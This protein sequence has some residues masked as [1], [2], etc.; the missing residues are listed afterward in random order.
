[1]HNTFRRPPT[2]VRARRTRLISPRGRADRLP[3]ALAAVTTGE[4][5]SPRHHSPRDP[6]FTLLPGALFLTLT[7]MVLA[8]L[9]LA[10]LGKHYFFRAP[11]PVAPQ[12]P[13][14]TSHR[15]DR[16]AVRFTTGRRSPHRVGP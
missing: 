16:R 5:C 15:L 10:E 3:G 8:Y 6:G 12:R 13:R 1:M 7:L 2:R 11:K 9:L 14:I 4:P